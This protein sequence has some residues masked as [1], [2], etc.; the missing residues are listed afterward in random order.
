M[1]RGFIRIVAAYLDGVRQPRPLLKPA[2]AG[3]SHASSAEIAFATILAAR[4]TCSCMP[5]TCRLL[6]AV[7]IDL[8][9]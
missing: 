9:F 3:I 8:A 2:A 7:Y 1:V 6:S 5:S 4:M